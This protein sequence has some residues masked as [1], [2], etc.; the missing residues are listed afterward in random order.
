[1]D[2][3][4]KSIM[5][6]AVMGAGGMGGWLGARLASAGA[7]VSFIARGNHL[8]AMRESGLK[9]IGA[10]N[11]ELPEV[12][13]TD[14]P[15]EIGYVD[16][17]L[18]CVKIYDTQAAASMLLPLLG[19]KTFVVT[20]QNGVESAGQI[21]KAI[22]K[23]RTLSGAAYFPANIAAPGKI[24]YVGRIQGKPHIAFGEPGGGPSERAHAFAT[25]CRSAG[26]DTEV[27]N[28]TEAMI[29]E[30][31][32]LVAATSA[33]TAVT[34]Q[35]VGIVRTDPDLRWILYRAIE[36]AA[37][38]ARKLGVNLEKDLESRT[39]D[40]IDQNPAD[41]KASQLIDLERGRPLELEGLSGTVVRLGRQTG[42]STPVHAT[43]YA[44]L[45][46]FKDGA[47]ANKDS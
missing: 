28:D 33:A 1:M 11:M 27:F 31:F 9:I 44:A 36:E 15:Q 26:I 29:W 34:R 21:S 39:L 16:V 47:Q 10:D 18:F 3:D 46:P 24:E 4:Y 2:F 13:A 41:G 22:G 20:V 5:K 8:K 43:V 40:F 12:V 37:Q 45:K 30:K 23:G 6:I 35:T 25:Q 42:I 14:N 19:P 7:N 38:T 17:I 32:C